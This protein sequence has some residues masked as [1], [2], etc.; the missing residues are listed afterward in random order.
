M[1]SVARWR[2]TVVFTAVLVILLVVSGV[3]IYFTTH[4]LIYHRVD[5][6][7]EPWPLLRAEVVNL[8]QDL[9]EADGLPPW[10]AGLLLAELPPAEAVAFAD[11]IGA[12]APLALR[13]NRLR[14]TR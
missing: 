2:L 13:A 8:R 11:T 9:V 1:F 3:A 10:L 6:E 7:H 14:A 12:P 5:A 4:S